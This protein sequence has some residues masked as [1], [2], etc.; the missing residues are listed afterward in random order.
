M[1]SSA[2]STTIVYASIASSTLVRVTRTKTAGVVTSEVFETEVWEL[3]DFP[4][5]APML[6]VIDMLKAKSAGMSEVNLHQ[7]IDESGDFASLEFF[8]M[9]AWRPSTPDEIKEFPAAEAKLIAASAAAKKLRA[10]QKAAEKAKEAKKAARTA[11]RAA[12]LAAASAVTLS[13]VK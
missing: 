6:E 1:T 2:P 3:I 5:S 10:S 8:Y 12:K 4:D 9:T 7:R 13:S 11:T